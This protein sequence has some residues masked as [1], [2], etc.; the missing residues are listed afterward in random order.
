MEIANK[1]Y[2]GTLG[3]PNVILHQ[4]GKFWFVVWKESQANIHTPR[5]GYF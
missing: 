4:I 5:I 1:T 3:T 2:V